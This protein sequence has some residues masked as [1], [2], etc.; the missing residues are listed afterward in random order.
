MIFSMLTAFALAAASAS[1]SEDWLVEDLRARQIARE[2]AKPLFDTVVSQWRSCLVPKAKT[3][4]RSRDSADLVARAAMVACSQ[5]EQP[6]RIGLPA[7][8]ALDN[9]SMPFLDAMRFAEMGIDRHFRLLK[10]MMVEQL[11]SQIASQ[12]A[13]SR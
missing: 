5:W 10:D 3:L 11:I 4:A 6:I 8:I 9:T 12:R 2:Q 13:V 1:K 7:Q